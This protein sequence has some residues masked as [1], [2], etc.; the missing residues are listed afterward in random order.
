MARSGPLLS[1][2]PGPPHVAG[3]R[4]HFFWTQ[5]GTAT[6]TK[7]VG[8]LVWSIFLILSEDFCAFLIPMSCALWLGSHMRSPE[9]T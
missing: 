6:N 2:A 8:R 9:W 1:V 7:W 5:W 3:P 4:K